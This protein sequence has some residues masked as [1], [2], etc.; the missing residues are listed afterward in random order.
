MP[1]KLMRMTNPYLSDPQPHGVARYMWF[2]KKDTSPDVDVRITIDPKDLSEALLR[3][4]QTMTTLEEVTTSTNGSIFFSVLDANMRY[5]QI[6]L[7]DESQ[8]LTTFNTPFRRYKYLRLPMGISSAPE[9]YQLA[10]GEM[11][12]DIKG[13]EIIMDGILIHAPTLEVHNQRLDR[14][15]RRC[16]Q[17]NLKLNKKKTKLCTNNVVYIGHVLSDEGVKIDDKKLKAVVNMPKHC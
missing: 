15:L 1:S 14:V 8:D 16:R 10:M 6:G 5:F 4:Y 13:V 3:E 9:I 11:F 2:T 7:T 17:Q 12:A